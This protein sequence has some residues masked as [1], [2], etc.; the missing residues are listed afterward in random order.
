MQELYLCQ[1]LP[2]ARRFS[3]LNEHPVPSEDGFVYSLM[4]LSFT[5]GFAAH[6]HG[7]APNALLERASRQVTGLYQA[8]GP[9]PADIAPRV[10]DRT[11]SCTFNPKAVQPGVTLVV[12]SWN[13]N[14]GWAPEVRLMDQ[15]STPLHP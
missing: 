3:R 8:W 11:G 5:Y 6:W 13:G 7:W 15:N 9:G 10:H 12:S 2:V 4:V 14:E 1:Y